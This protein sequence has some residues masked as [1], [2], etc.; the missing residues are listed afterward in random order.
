M[1]NRWYFRSIT[2]ENYLQTAND[3]LTS[4]HLQLHIHPP[5]F[6]LRQT[7]VCSASTKSSVQFVVNSLLGADRV[8]ALDVFM[9]GDDVPAKKP[10]PSIYR[11]AAERLGLNPAECLV[12]EDSKIG[13]QAALGADMRCIIT[14]TSSSASQVRHFFKCYFYLIS[15]KPF[16]FWVVFVLIVGDFGSYFYFLVGCVCVCVHAR[17]CACTCV[18]VC[19]K[20]V[21]RLVGVY[22]WILFCVLSFFC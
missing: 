1:T 2:L 11:I 12:V 8:A 4:P 21:L 9:A 16:F 13:L 3:H 18:R 19:V 5:S 14:Y 15:L 17:A 22:S 10:D 20:V 7:A 6:L